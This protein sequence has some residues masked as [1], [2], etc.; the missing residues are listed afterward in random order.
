MPAR[1][2]AL[3]VDDDS[4]SRLLVCTLLE[5]LLVERVLPVESGRLALEAIERDSSINLLVCDLRMPDIDGVALLSALPERRFL[6]ILIISGLDRATLDIAFHAAEARGLDVLGSLEKPITLAAL[7]PMIEQVR[8]RGAAQ[9]DRELIPGGREGLLS[10]LE[11]SASICL[12]QPVMSLSNG[13]LSGIAVRPG[14]HEEAGIETDICTIARRFGLLRELT[15]STLANAGQLFL[16][17]DHQV[18]DLWIS[19][20]LDG[21]VLADRSFPD[22]A[23]RCVQSHWLEPEQVVFEVRLNDVTANPVACLEVIA[24]LRVMGFQIALDTEYL[25]VRTPITD[26]NIP[27]QQLRLSMAR[28]RGEQAAALASETSVDAMV[29]AAHARAA[30]ALAVA[31]DSGETLREVDALHIDLASGPAVDELLGPRVGLAPS[32]PTGGAGARH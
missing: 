21:S 26:V 31:V 28:I 32:A 9:E 18:A 29:T 1:I 14:W 12:P 17:Q 2:N 8:Q 5:K 20:G 6:P 16:A 10:L 24:R 22:L 3:V 25:R 7:E 13:E 27:F 23:K 4:A 15:L 30:L 19:L 11:K